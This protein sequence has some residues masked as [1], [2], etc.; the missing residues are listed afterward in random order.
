[1][2][3]RPVHGLGVL[4]CLCLFAAVAAA[5]EPPDAAAL[6]ARGQAQLAQADFD[7]ALRS[8]RAAA[9][10]APG[11]K[12]YAQDALVLRRVVGMRKTVARQQVNARWEKTAI[13]LHL[14]YL[15]N[16]LPQEAV[17]LDR[18]GLRLLANAGAEARLAEALLEAGDNEATVKLLDQ[19]ARWQRDQRHA[20]F[21]GIALARTKQ[22]A[23]ALKVHESLR[24]PKNASPLLLRDAARLE[25]VLGREPGCA[26]LLKR[27]FETTPPAN[28]ATFKAQ[29]RAHPDFRG[30]AAGP[31]FAQAMQTASKV[32]P[33]GCSGG[34]DCGSC[35]SRGSCGG[36]Q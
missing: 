6:H 34:K 7:G 17:A 28:L 12:T 24:L 1:M 31:T 32:K 11:N 35:P 15:R 25:A 36:K 22:Y 2:T 33:V 14:F 16:D 10:A 3:S 8:F 29:V 19:P 20:I 13:S 23:R 27:S 18:R 21:H 5:A 4:L 9:R 26:A 30:V